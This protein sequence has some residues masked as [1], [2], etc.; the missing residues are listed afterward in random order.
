MEAA[1]NLYESKIYELLGFQNAWTDK[2]ICAQFT[3]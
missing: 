2:A 1:N 3:V